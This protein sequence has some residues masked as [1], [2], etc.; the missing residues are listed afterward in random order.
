MLAYYRFFG[1]K[2][3]VRRTQLARRCTPIHFST[4]RERLFFSSFTTFCQNFCIW[5]P[6]LRKKF[7]D[8]I[9]FYYF[10]NLIHF[11]RVTGGN[12]AP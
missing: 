12:F 3:A 5:V 11:V 2:V 10:C 7:A 8:I 4:K 9:F 6:I 1:Q